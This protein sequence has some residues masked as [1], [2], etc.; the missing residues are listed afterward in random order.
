MTDFSENECL[1]NEDEFQDQ[2][3]SEDIETNSEKVGYIITRL[4]DGTEQPVQNKIVELN[5]NGR[6]KWKRGESY[7]C[8][9][10][11]NW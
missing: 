6:E 10:K 7:V 2:V 4:K 8:T 11:V 9:A 5:R 3:E 1:S